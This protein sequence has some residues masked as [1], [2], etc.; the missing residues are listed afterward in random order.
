[1]MKK[2]LAL[3]LA[4]AVLASMLS[5]SALGLGAE[6]FSDVKES[7]WYYEDVD[8]MAKHE[9]MNGFPDGTFR[10]QDLLTREQVAVIFARIWGADVSNNDVAPYDDVVPGRYSSGAIQWLKD[11]GLTTGTGNNKFSPQGTLTRQEFATFAARFTKYYLEE[12]PDVTLVPKNVVDGFNDMDQAADWAVESIEYCREQ[13]LLYG[14]PDGSFRPTDKTT[15]AQIAAVFHRMIIELQIVPDEPTPPK[16]TPTPTPEVPAE[17]D[18]IGK[19]VEKAAELANNTVIPGLNGSYLRDYV[20]LS[21]TDVTEKDWSADD[22]DGA[23]RELT[24]TVNGELDAD[25]AVKLLHIASNAILPYLKV[26]NGDWFDG[27]ESGADKD[28]AV[29]ERLKA[30]AQSLIDDFNA[31]TG[32]ALTGADAKELAQKLFD[33]YKSTAAYAQVKDYVNAGQGLYRECFLDDGLY[34]AGSAVIKVNGKEIATV[35]ITADGKI[36]TLSISKWTAIKNFTIEMAKEMYHSVQSQTTYSSTLNAS[37]K[38]EVVFTDS[39]VAEVGDKTAK[40]PH[41][42]VLNVYVNM[43][44][45]LFAYKF[46]DGINGRNHVAVNLTTAAMD[47]LATDVS[48]ILNF[49]IDKKYDELHDKLVTEL[50]SEAMVRV[51]FLGIYDAAGGELTGESLLPAIKTVM[52]GSHEKEIEALETY[53]GTVPASVRAYALARIAYLINAYLDPNTT[54]DSVELVKAMI[55]NVT[56]G[57]IAAI[58]SN[59]ELNTFITTRPI[60]PVNRVKNFIKKYLPDSASI[61]VGE[62]KEELNKASLAAFLAAANMKDTVAAF[63]DLVNA[64][65]TLQG[66]SLQSVHDNPLLIGAK[67]GSYGPRHFR[68]AVMFDG[69]L[70]GK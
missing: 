45:E 46:V 14:F 57:D 63:C 62:G 18:L 19:A 16:P 70:I 7:S 55:P 20:N 51:A 39:A 47:E 3:L 27:T 67:A 34:V 43:T 4:V 8:F 1:M 48:K 60:G 29:K 40:Y 65:T 31:V 33:D 36:A 66:L 10:P 41:D 24:L 12:H 17:D 9:Y 28:E 15:R 21:A 2:I 68:L 61:Y 30:Y 5:I 35:N 54:D 32:L 37:S 23:T 64:S 59:P 22:K 69:D 38:V 50:G 44:S 25:I 13:G 52:A 49:I 53:L 42:Y 58:L 6:D 26:D 11:T 56:L